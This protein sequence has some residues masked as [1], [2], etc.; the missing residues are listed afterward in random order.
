MKSQHPYISKAGIDRLVVG[1]LLTLLLLI[2]TGCGSLGG[3]E[4]G[5]PSNSGD[6]CNDTTEASDADDFTC[7]FCFDEP[8]AA[9]ACEDCTSD[10]AGDGAAIECTVDSCSLNEVGTALFGLCDAAVACDASVTALTCV[11]AIYQD[12]STLDAFGVSTAYL[13]FEAVQTAVDEGS[14]VVSATVLENCAEALAAVSCTELSTA[15][16][17]IGAGDF[18]PLSAVVPTECTDVF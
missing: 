17:Q 15:G 18:S 5:N 3:T 16:Y 8:E 9:V 1:T 10:D 2:I 4:C 12:R 6:T 7:T 13:S 11:E 14:M